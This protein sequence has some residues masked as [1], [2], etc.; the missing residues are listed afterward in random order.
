MSTQTAAPDAKH[1]P[2]QAYIIIALGVAGISLASTF[3]K[4]AQNE[5]IPSLFIAAARMGIAAL[6][7]TPITLRRYVGEL[8]GITRNE[9]RLAVVSGVFLA[10]HFAT[11]ILSFEYTSVLVSVVL[12]DTN[13]LWVAAM[14][15]FF[16]RERLGR[17]V[18]TGLVIGIV[19]SIVVALPAGGTVTLGHNPLLGSLL[20]FIGA[21]AVAV[22]FVIG[23]KLRARLSLLPYIW[24]V[25]SC[26]AVVLLITVAFMNISAIGYSAQGYLWL[27]ATALVPQLI[28]HSSLNFALKYFPATYVGIAAQLEPV[29]SAAIAFFVF[30][31]IPLALQILG[32]AVVLAGVIFA[33]VGQARSKSAAQAISTPISPT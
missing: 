12:V 18:I 8:R 15:V 32:S 22:Y 9:L 27:A 17:W 3:I 29:M 26:S 7:L 25:Y 14:E 30:G 4:L 1:T 23:R 2:V 6:V 11:W 20:A 13:P 5:H 16:L 19:G 28:G 24:L 31:E 33:S 21:L 10:L